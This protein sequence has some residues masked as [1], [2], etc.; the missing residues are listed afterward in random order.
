MSAA[1]GIA[2]DGEVAAEIMIAITIVT[3]TVAVI[4][5]GIVIVTPAVDV[6]EKEI[7]IMT[8]AVA[9]K[10]IVITV[11]VAKRIERKN[12]TENERTDAVAE[13][14]WKPDLL[15]RFLTLVDVKKISRDR[16]C[17]CKLLSGNR[18][19]KRKTVG[20]KCLPFY[21]VIRVRIV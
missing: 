20:V 9:E 11:A 3:A 14:P 21:S 1:A 16:C 19:R 4:V 17:K 2:P 6:Q 15:L 7:A 13:E 12:A 10:E 18:M 5:T 8:V